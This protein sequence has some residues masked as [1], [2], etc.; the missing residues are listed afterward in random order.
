MKH[1][2]EI[3]LEI[4]ATG[5]SNIRHAASRGDA[6]HCYREADHLHNLPTLIARGTRSQERFYLDIER[7]EYVKSSPEHYRARYKEL[8]EELEAAIREET[9]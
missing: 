9:G 5:L 7:R 8:W 3:V 1:K 4:L 6:D 2:S